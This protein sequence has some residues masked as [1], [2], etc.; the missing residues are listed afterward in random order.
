MIQRHNVVLKK[1][2]G[3]VEVYPMKQWLREHPEVLPGMDPDGTTS[4]ELRR[5]LRNKGWSLEETED[6]VLLVKP[7][8]NGDTSFVGEL[9]G[10]KT[11]T[12]A[13]D[14][15]EQVEKAE[16]ITFGLERD[17]QAALR[18]HIEQLEPG[19]RIV[20]EGKERVTDAGRIDITATDSNRN[21]VIIELKAGIA[22]PD[23]VAQILAYMGAIGDSD[24]APVRGILVAGNFHK[25]VILAARAIPNLQ[26][27]RY[28]FQFSFESVP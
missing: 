27:K 23:A 25:R 9:L 20:D 8:L 28:S 3:G 11:D 10:S 6:Q 16:E 13:A 15:E 22:Q 24:K 26:L 17:L 14:D 1:P 21:V 4:H 2:D 18:T 7:D 19:L 12:R 5:A